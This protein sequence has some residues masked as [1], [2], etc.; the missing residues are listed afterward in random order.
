LKELDRGDAQRRLDWIVTRMTWKIKPVPKGFTVLG[1]SEEG[2][3]GPVANP[4]SR[5]KWPLK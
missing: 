2:S 3:V 5:G 1:I 4:G